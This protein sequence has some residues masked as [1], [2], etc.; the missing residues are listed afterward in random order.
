MQKSALGAA[1]LFVVII[2]VAISIWTVYEGTVT[3]VGVPVAAGFA[4]IIGVGLMAADMS[5]RQRRSLGKSILPALGFLGI[6]MLASGPSHFNFF[7]YKTIGERDARDRLVEAEASFS[8]LLKAARTQLGT[9]DSVKQL[10]DDAE[11]LI[12][13]YRQQVTYGNNPGYGPE[14]DKVVEQIID[15]VD[16]ATMRKLRVF[17]P[18]QRALAWLDETLRPGVTTKIES[19]R[20][21]NEVSI[22]LGRIN[23][24]ETQLKQTISEKSPSGDI[25]RLPSQSSLELI[26]AFKD[27]HVQ[28]AGI[29]TNRLAAITGA[30]PFSSS[31]E[32]ISPDVVVQNDIP[33]SLASGFG[34][35]PYPA[36]TAFAV[37]ASLL[38]D[39]IPTLFVL[40]LATGK[41]EEEL[42][43]LQTPSTKRNKKKSDD[44]LEIN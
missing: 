41:Q 2:C 17:T 37:A 42:A 9:H 8:A 3:L 11:V 34:R 5:I 32:A 29:A 22:D 14:A 44:V 23:T 20:A 10:E 31:A 36:E 12:A 7:Y 38:I 1:Y 21:S 30:N 28:I 6:C 25:R 13:E 27:T 16:P 4:G 33:S 39:L 15:L 24:L 18:E 19:L 26:T 35:M 43:A 40:L